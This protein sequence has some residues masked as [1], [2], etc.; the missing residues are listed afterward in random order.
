MLWYRAHVLLPLGGI[1]LPFR[2]FYYEYIS[3][4]PPHGSGEH[5][6]NDLRELSVDNFLNIN[7]LTIVVLVLY[8]EWTALRY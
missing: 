8:G 5:L 4:L 1:F 2:N 3:L 7:I 6:V